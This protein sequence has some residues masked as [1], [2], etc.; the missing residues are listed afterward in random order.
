MTHCLNTLA[1]LPSVSALEFPI[2]YISPIL[3]VIAYFPTDRKSLPTT[4]H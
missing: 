1:N 2:L 3:P 4:V